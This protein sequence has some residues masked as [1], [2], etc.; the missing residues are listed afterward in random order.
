VFLHATPAGWFDSPESAVA[1]ATVAAQL[2]MAVVGAAVFVRRIRTRPI[3]LCPPSWTA[4][5][6]ETTSMARVAPGVG[7]RHL[8]DYAGSVVPLM[9]I[10]TMGVRPLAAAVVA[11]KIFTLFCRVPQAC[12]SAAFVHYG[13]ALGRR[14]PDLPAVVRRLRRYAAVPTGAAVLATVVLSPWLVTAF[15]PPD[16]DLSLARWLMAA[17]LITVPAYFF[18][19]FAGELLTVHQRGGRLAAAST[20]ATYVLTI[21]LAGWAVFA[22]DSAFLGVATKTLSIVL[23]AG[24]FWRLLGRE[25]RA[26]TAVPVD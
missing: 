24:V 4:I 15:A 13:Y 17:Y 9:F 21:P 8:N 12:F 5:R 14:D 3:P 22:A 10:G 16:L 6:A 11:T 18:E 26:Q 2:L 20:I 25:L 7:A 23:L 19:Q 1:T